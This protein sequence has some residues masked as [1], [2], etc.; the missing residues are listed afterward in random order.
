YDNRTA[1]LAEWAEPELADMR[2]Q[3]LLEGLF[4]DT[5]LDDLLANL[6]P[7]EVDSGGGGDEFEEEIDTKQSRVSLGDIWQVGQHRVMCADSTKLP[8]VMQLMDGKQGVGVFTSPPYA[9][10]RAAHYESIPEEEY[11][12]WWEPLQANMRVALSS[13]G[14]FFLNMKAHTVAGERSLYV[15]KLVIDMKERHKWRY[16]DELCWVH[17]TPPGSWPDRFKNGWESVF[18]FAVGNVKFRPRNVRYEG[19]VP[20]SSSPQKKSIGTGGYY[21]IRTRNIPGFAYPDNVIDT[22][23]P[24]RGIDH[25]AI[26]P[27]ALP[28]FFMAAYSDPRDLWIDPFIGSGTSL[29]A[30]HRTSRVCYGLDNSPPYCDLTLRR[31]EAEGIEPIV[32]LY[33]Q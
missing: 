33:P 17:I 1:E 30:A 12:E 14:S 16:V 31:A 25:P 15:M 19:I 22:G 20:D 9:E 18:H 24:D 27:V 21:N 7:E 32:R 6:S 10:Q 23:T 8:N 26:F 5:E 4:F 11:I 13:D 28:S 2:Q 3:G 29:V